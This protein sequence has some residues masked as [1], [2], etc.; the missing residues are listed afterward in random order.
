M[1]VTRL[2]VASERVNDDEQDGDRP[3]G[4]LFIHTLLVVREDGSKVAAPDADHIVYLGQSTS[5]LNN[6]TP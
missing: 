3:K 2:D 6:S 4:W 5:S 1:S